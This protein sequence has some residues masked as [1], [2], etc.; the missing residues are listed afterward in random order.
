MAAI[1]VAGGAPSYPYGGAPIT[2]S[3]DGVNWPHGSLGV[4]ANIAT[5]GSCW[6]PELGLFVIVGNG[7]GNDYYVTRKGCILTSQDGVAW[8][9]R[10]NDLGYIFDVVWISELSIFVAVGTPSPTHPAFVATSPDGIVWTNQSSGLETL[11]YG[12]NNIC[13]SPELGLMVAVSGFINPGMAHSS[14]GINWTPI[15]GG[16]GSNSIYDLAWSSLLGVFV[17]VGG[18]MNESYQYIKDIAYSVDGINWTH[19]VTLGEGDQTVAWSP[20]L[21]MFLAIDDGSDTIKSVDGINWTNGS[22]LALHVEQVLWSVEFHLFILIGYLQGVGRVSTS[23]DGTYWTYHDIDA[24]PFATYMNTVVSGLDSPATPS[25]IR[26]SAST[27]SHGPIFNHSP[28]TI[29]AST[30]SHSPIFNL[31]PISIEA[32]GVSSQG[33]SLEGY[34][35]EPSDILISILLT[36]RID[37][38]QPTPTP[39]VDFPGI[40]NPIVAPICVASDTADGHLAAGTYRYAYAAWVGD[41]GQATA[42]SPL[43]EPVTLTTEDTVTMTYPVILGADGYIVYRREMD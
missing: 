30:R 24:W 36:G 4:G 29:G 35:G 1:L 14:D 13:W 37:P 9:S 17:A 7:S 28:F 10:T 26:I 23:P 31:A 40:P 20:E 16:F 6:S 2:Y 38:A 27:R 19:A 43:S 22:S 25:P 3:Y 41:I 5:Y 42:P 15:D 18:G 33:G 34:T 32:S 11:S 21:E 12:L 39:P 8:T